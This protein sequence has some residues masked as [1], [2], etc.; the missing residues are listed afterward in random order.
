ML[1]FLVAHWGLLLGGGGVLAAVVGLCVLVGPAVL[2]ARWRLVLGGAVVLVAGATVVYLWLAL[3]ATTAKLIVA[4]ANYATVTGQNVT[5]N[6]D[7]KNLAAQTLLQS[8]SIQ[9]VAD[10]AREAK[11]AA[12]AALATAV[13]QQS[14]DQSSIVALQARMKDPKTNAGS[15]DDEIARIRSTL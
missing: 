4:Q 8:K 11:T 1:S 10:G 2:L 14:V 3:E 7:N 13:A 5:L 15:C 6:A 12:D 9:L